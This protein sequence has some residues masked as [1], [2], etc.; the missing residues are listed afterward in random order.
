MMIDR[1]RA[2]HS[3]T[4]RYALAPDAAARAA[5]DATFVE[6]GRMMEM[7]EAMTEGSDAGANLV[8]LHALAYE[9]LRTATRLPSQMVVLGLRDFAARRSG[10]APEGLPL[11][12]KLFAVKG[13]AQVSIATVEGRASVPYVVI[14]YR[15]GWRGGPPA[16]LVRDGDGFHVHIGVTPRGAKQQETEMIHEGIL[17]RMGR[18]IAGFAHAAVDRAEALDTVAV[19]EQAVREIDK[20]ADEVRAEVGKAQAERYRIESRREAFR[21][22]SAKLETQI[23]TAVAQGRDDLAKA[24]IGRQ[25]DLEAQVAA[26]DKALADVDE[27][28]D[29]SRQALQAVV[30][31]RKDAEARLTE[32]KKSEAKAGAPS[33]ATGGM[34][35]RPEDRVARKAASIARLTG[36]PAGDLPAGAA[37][38]EELERLHREQ[39][40]EARLR[41]RTGPAKT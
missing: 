19:V 23:D 20:A 33:A 41:A 34:A 32:L 10:A 16:R 39:T 37:E 25:L 6:Y 28:L 29:E 38:L 4:L 11:D 5:I 18:L 40:I 8:A 36:V 3:D 21:A 15:P 14:G 31:A 35:E 17:A 30:A 9:R 26:L 1:S 12:D 22:E 7:L 24:A 27:R 2:S 13:A